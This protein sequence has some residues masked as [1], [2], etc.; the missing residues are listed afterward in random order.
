MADAM[1]LET[2]QKGLCIELETLLSLKPGTITVDTSLPTLGVDSLRFVSL[3]LA[4]E[5]RFG[6][7]LMKIGIKQDDLKTV[8]TLAA[9]VKAGRAD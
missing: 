6:V 8:V 1:T 3:L 7:N 9:A 4:I 5:Q 2:I